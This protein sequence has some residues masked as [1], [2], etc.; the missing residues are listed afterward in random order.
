MK[1]VFCINSPIPD[2]AAGWLLWW[3]WLGCLSVAL[4]LVSVSGVRLDWRGG[5]AAPSLTEPLAPHRLG[6]RHV[7]GV[8]VRLERHGLGCVADHD[9]GAAWLGAGLGAGQLGLVPA[10]CQPRPGPWPR[11]C[12]DLAAGLS[13]Q[14]QRGLVSQAILLNSN[15]QSIRIMW[16]VH[17]FSKLLINDNEWF[18]G[19]PH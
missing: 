16:T 3:G 13:Q 18:C 7:F 15:E 9:G 1:K 2:A 6:C 8:L 17:L 4:W 12:P 14:L 11:V 10:L 5:L 19:T